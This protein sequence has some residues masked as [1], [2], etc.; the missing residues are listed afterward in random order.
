M[1]Q[2]LFLFLF[3]TIYHHDVGCPQHQFLNDTARKPPPTNS[4]GPTAPLP[5]FDPIDTSN[6]TA[7]IQ[8]LNRLPSALLGT[9]HDPL[10][11]GDRVLHGA[12][13][14]TWSTGDFGRP[15]HDPYH[16]SESPVDVSH[17]ATLPLVDRRR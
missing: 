11:T 10:Q 4:E 13:K 16:N 6:T 1:W 3:L 7:P 14:W 2:V 5:P 15:E 17:R 12:A 8:H 9:T